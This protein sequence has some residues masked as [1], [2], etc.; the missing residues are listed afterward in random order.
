MNSADQP[1]QG[2]RER[3]IRILIALGS[4]ITGGI[5]SLGLMAALVLHRAPREVRSSFALRKKA[6]ADLLAIESALR[7]FSLANRGKYPDSLEWLVTPDLNGYTFLDRTSIPEAPWGRVCVY[8]PPAPDRQHPSVLSCGRDGRP[9]GAGEDAD[10][11]LIS[12]RNAR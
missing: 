7:G 8:T 5:A 9:G 3:R 2:K 6:E 4:F 10:I 1:D 11:D 12:I